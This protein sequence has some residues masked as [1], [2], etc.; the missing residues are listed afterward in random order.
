MTARRAGAE[1]GGLFGAVVLQPIRIEC[2]DVGDVIEKQLRTG[3]DVDLDFEIGGV[4]EFE[5]VRAGGHDGGAFLKHAEHAAGVARRGRSERGP[6]AYFFRYVEPRSDA[7]TK[8]EAL[9]NILTK[10]GRPVSTGILKS[11]VHVELLGTR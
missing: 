9:F 8:Q 4:A 11:S 10:G 6:E 5:Q 2:E 7:R 1:V 3:E